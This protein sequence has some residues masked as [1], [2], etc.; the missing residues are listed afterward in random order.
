MTTT[1]G[2]EMGLDWTQD[3]KD[4]M[5]VGMQ[6]TPE[7]P[8]I[9]DFETVQLRA[10]LIKEEAGEADEAIFTNN[11]PEIAKECI[12]IL[13]VT[14]GTMVAY[15][16]DPRPIWDAVHASNMDKFRDGVIKDKGGKILKPPGWT[17]PNIQ[18]LLEEQQN[19]H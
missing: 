11:L 19:E 4:F 10:R 7:L 18:S 17:K 13:V 16:V 14:I 1:Y 2:E 5:S 6:D 12:D 15:G 8:K 9:P 3:I